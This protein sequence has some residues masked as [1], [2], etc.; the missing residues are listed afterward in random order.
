MLWTSRKQSHI[1][2]FENYSSRISI[3]TSANVLQLTLH[4]SNAATMKF[5]HRSF[6]TM[7]LLSQPR[8]IRHPAPLNA[9]ELR[10]WQTTTVALFILGGTRVQSVA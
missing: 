6:L 4:Q 9:A 1:L 2:S 5:A 7:T 3:N 8:L 10:S